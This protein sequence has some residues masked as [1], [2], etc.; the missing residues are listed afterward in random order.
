MKVM[1]GLFLWLGGLIIG[2]S[3]CGVIY[4][5]CPYSKTYTKGVMDALECNMLLDLELSAKG[6][7][8]K[9]EERNEIVKQR[10]LFGRS[11]NKS[12]AVG[13]DEDPWKKYDPPEDTE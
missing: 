6:E 12:F 9:W 11:K 10:L 8:M 5:D 1:G 4:G 7:I 3:I 13:S 2:L